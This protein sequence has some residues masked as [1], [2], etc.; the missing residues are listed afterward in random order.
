MM[1]V[2]GANGY[3]ATHTLEQLVKARQEPI[4]ALV[5]HEAQF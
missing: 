2:S 4:K 1:L 5:R 3:V